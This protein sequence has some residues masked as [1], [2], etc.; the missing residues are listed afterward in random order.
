MLDTRRFASLLLD[1]DQPI[2]PPTLEEPLI[3]PITMREAPTPPPAPPP[4]APGA[5]ADPPPPP[6]P[7]AVA[8]PPPLAPAT[9]MSATESGTAPA[10]T[11]PTAESATAPTADTATTGAPAAPLD[12]PA[13]AELVDRLL[14]GL[15]DPT[16][17]TPV[18]ETDH[19]PLIAEIDAAEQAAETWL[20]DFMTELG[21][22]AGIAPDM[23]F[24]A[25]DVG[26]IDGGWPL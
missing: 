3:W 10:A 20:R 11:T 14:A 2:A 9:T 16:E 18:P 21:D 23:A 8:D 5:V 7:G 13:L 12:D 6:A 26:E 25:G 15:P 1:L 22:G 24:D 17:G 19:T 4:T